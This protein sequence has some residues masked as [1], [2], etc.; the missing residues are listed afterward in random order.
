VIQEDKLI[1]PSRKEIVMK[2]FCLIILLALANSSASSG[3]AQD[4]PIKVKT[5]GG[6]TII[7]DKTKPTRRELE[8]VFEQRMKAAKDLNFD[9]QMALISPDY[10]A[11]LANGTTWKYEQI[12]DH[13]RR[14]YEQ[15]VRTEN[16]TC[17]IKI[18]ELTVCG[19]EAIIEARQYCPRKQRLR[20]GKVHDVYTSVLQ[21]FLG[22]QSGAR[23]A[24]FRSFGA[25]G[26]ESR[27]VR[28]SSGRGTFIRRP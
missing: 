21:T 15:T 4:D 13:I 20:D 8:A 1:E 16:Y 2:L 11:T 5:K 10:T 23:L 18:E 3:Y 17:E 25:L 12:R 7:K 6:V 24:G 14:L 9:A 27:G 26:V 19:N 22:K 28:M